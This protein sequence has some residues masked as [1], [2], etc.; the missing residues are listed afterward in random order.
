MIKDELVIRTWLHQVYHTEVLRYWLT[1]DEGQ[2][3][4]CHSSA[5]AANKTH[6]NS[7]SGICPSNFFQFLLPQAFIDDMAQQDFSKFSCSCWCPPLLSHSFL[8]PLLS[9]S[10]KLEVEYCFVAICSKTLKTLN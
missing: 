8:V 1:F 7:S 4:S 3:S 10:I 5:S 2:G 6:Q 9:Y